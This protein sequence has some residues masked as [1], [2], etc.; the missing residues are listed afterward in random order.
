MSKFANCNAW[1]FCQAKHDW[2]NEFRL[3]PSCTFH[4]SLPKH[5][6]NTPRSYPPPS[7]MSLR[8]L[9]SSWDTLQ[10]KPNI[11]WESNSVMQNM[12]V[13]L[14]VW[15]S[16]I[17]HANCHRADSS[18][19]PKEISLTS[20]PSIAA[21]LFS[22]FPSFLFPMSFF[23]FHTGPFLGFDS[24]RLPLSSPFHLSAHST[25]LTFWPF[26]SSAY[27]LWRDFCARMNSNYL[28]VYVARCKQTA[29]CFFV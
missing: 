24:L 17:A 23:L 27:D 12:R 15:L 22:L 13:C 4:T 2:Y 28:Y 26:Q 14:W 16:W 19:S 9:R 11:L 20:L 21:S 6:M 3:K 8:S 5:R 10:K 1:L 18:P 29:T 25:G 7:R